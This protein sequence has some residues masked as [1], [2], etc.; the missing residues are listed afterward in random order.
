M[1]VTGKVITVQGDPVNHAIVSE[2]GTFNEVET[3]A[4]GAFRIP[5]T[6]GNELLVTAFLMDPKV[7]TVSENNGPIEVVLTADSELLE[8]VFTPKKKKRR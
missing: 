5:L 4:Q 1:V 2:K 8:V 3:N 6:S 7:I